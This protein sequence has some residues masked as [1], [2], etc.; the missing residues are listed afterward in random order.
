LAPVIIYL[1]G[2]RQHAGKTFMSLGIISMLRKVIDPA[3]IGYIKPVGQELVSLPDGAKID[4]DAYLIQAFSRI[5]GIDLEAIS[6]V[7][8]ASGFTQ[9]YLS[10]N[11]QLEET[12]RLED[13]IRNS[14][15][16]LEKKKVIIAEG[17]GHPGVGGIVGLSNADVGNIID[18]DIIFLS[19]GGIGK[20]LDM[21]EVDLS[22]FLYK[23]SRVRGIIFNKL[24]PKKIKTVSQFI[25]EDLINKKY[26]AFGGP[27]RILGFMPQVDFL[28][29]PSM[30]TL[31]DKLIDSEALNDTT[32]KS[33]KI[34][35]GSIRVISV[36]YN[37]LK[38][39]SYLK[40]RDLV[41]LGASS[42]RKIRKIVEYSRENLYTKRIGG[43]ILTCGRTD[44][45]DQDLR[46]LIASSGIP[47]L[48]IQ[49]DT[50]TAEE[51]VLKIFENTKIQ[52]FD[53]IKVKEIER[54]FEEYFDFDKFLDTFKL[55]S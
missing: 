11:D 9:N 25:T 28:S 19:G 53:S 39:D 16:E 21:L 22:Y 34:P 29:K 49:Q 46:N 30:L 12:R 47:A 26:G 33:W 17:S 10:S 32:N 52:V 15:K 43:I 44:V 27:L 45:L 55:K 40:P 8:L 42:K 23:K 50:A 20:A 1:T 36:P 51:T 24:F 35:C 14:V 38:L 41:I 18:A 13:K 54:L 48:Y 37:S 3:L 31:Q 5:P 2:F 6:P 7:R 4:K